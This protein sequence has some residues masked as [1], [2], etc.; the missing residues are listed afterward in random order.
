MAEQ[1]VLCPFCGTRNRPD[2][3]FCARCEESLEGAQP[4]VD[5][6]TAK[7]PT[8]KV[9]LLERAEASALSGSAVL[10]VSVL[11]FGVLDI[12]DQLCAIEAGSRSGR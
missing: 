7:V 2:W 12:E 10:I 3:D 6:T 8:L 1:A 11:A 9:E 4:A 5:E